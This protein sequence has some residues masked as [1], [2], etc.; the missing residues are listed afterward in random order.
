MEEIKKG[1]KQTDIGVIPKDW[2]IRPIGEVLKVTTGNKNTQDKK[3]D[4]IYPFFVRS[5]TVERINT[6]TFDGEG[7]LTAGDGVGTGKVF[8]YINGKFDYH[9]RVYLMHGF[10]DKVLGKYFFWFFSKYFY[11]RINQLTAKSSVDSVRREMIADMLMPLP[12]KDEQ[13]AIATALS[14]TDVLIAALDKKIAKKQQIK[15]GAMQQ[16]LTGKKRLSGFSGETKYKETEI[17]LIPEDWEIV[18]VSDAFKFLSTASFSRDELGVEGYVQCLHYGDIH[19]KY[20]EYIDFKNVSLPKVLSKKGLNYPH[21]QE[22]DI[23]MADASEDYSGLCKSVEIRNIGNNK[24]ISGLHTILLREKTNIFTNGFKAYLFTISEVRIQ[25][26]EQSTGM[27]VFGVSKKNLG[28]IILPVPLKSEQTAIA[29]ILTDMDNEIAQLE[30]ER[31]KYK[32]LK[33]GMMQVLLTG[34]VRLV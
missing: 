10:D 30:K 23:V 18:T 33:A 22:G 21:I 9:Q 29:Q 11:E 16:L 34:K 25:L 26:I 13:T 3:D 5:Q 17:G 24:V 8:H 12:K 19:T 31:D 4:G 14:D 32:E 1:Y 20:D 2:D 6:Y 7:V 28:Q 15:Q 27:K